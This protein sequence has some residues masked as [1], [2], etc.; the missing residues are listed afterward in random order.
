MSIQ[1]CSR[2]CMHPA[3]PI[4]CICMTGPQRTCA[5]RH[6]TME[7]QHGKP[8]VL[9][10]TIFTVLIRLGFK[11]D[12][13][14]GIRKTAQLVP[15]PHQHG[16][17]QMDLCGWSSG[18]LRF[19]AGERDCSRPRLRRWRNMKS[20]R[21]DRPA[22]HANMHATMHAPKGCSQNPRSGGLLHRCPWT[23]GIWR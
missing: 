2:S 21:Q 23:G 20:G 4:Q 5:S 9:I 10:L 3:D 17:A 12:L 13:G 8:H 11:T 22:M 1:G 15:D 19:A 18:R 7:R 16:N 6:P 14:H